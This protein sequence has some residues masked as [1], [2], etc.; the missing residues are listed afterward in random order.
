M[1]AIDASLRAGKPIILRVGYD[2]AVGKSRHNGDFTMHFIVISG[3]HTNEQGQR[4][5]EFFDPATQ[6]LEKGTQGNTLTFEHEQLK[7][8][9]HGRD[10]T[11][12]QVR[13]NR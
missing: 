1:D 6:S 13:S 2:D 8:S 11:V 4:V 12:T 3:Y 10:Y 7:G 5:Y 9:F